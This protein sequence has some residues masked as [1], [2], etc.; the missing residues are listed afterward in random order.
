ME[1]DPIGSRVRHTT[2]KIGGV[3][4]IPVEAGADL[5]GQGQLMAVADL[6][7]GVRDLCGKVGGQ[8]QRGAVP[9]ADDL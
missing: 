9:I 1:G 6:C 7:C 5:D 3:D 8:H 4:V 2:G